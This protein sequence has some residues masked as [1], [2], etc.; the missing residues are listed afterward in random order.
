M[1]SEHRWCDKGLIAEL[2]PVFLV[3]LM[4]HLDVDIQGVLPFKGGITVMA[5]KGPLTLKMKK[6]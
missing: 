2:T 6:K 3:S 5:L 4:N 1:T